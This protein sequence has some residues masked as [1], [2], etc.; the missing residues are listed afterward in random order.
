MSDSNVVT[1]T[2]NTRVYNIYTGENTIT[3]DHTASND[4][5]NRVCSMVFAPSLIFEDEG[6]YLWLGMQD[7]AVLVVDIVSGDII[8]K[9]TD[10]HTCAVTTML[11]YRNEEIWTIDDG[12]ILWNFIL[13]KTKCQA[14]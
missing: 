2:H 8:G 6:R 9:R 11:R 13:G 5:S 10:A 14:N 7:G 4:V 12:A 3:M 1:G